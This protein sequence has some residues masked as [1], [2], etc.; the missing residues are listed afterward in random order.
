MEVHII[1]VCYSTLNYCKLPSLNF[2]VPGPVRS[3]LATPLLVNGVPALNVRWSPPVDKAQGG[4][5]YRLRVVPPHVTISRPVTTTVYIVRDLRANTIYT[6]YV[7]AGST[8]QYGP[9]V[10]TVATTVVSE[11]CTNDHDTALYYPEEYLVM[12]DV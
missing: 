3:L 12:S 8:A 11:C 4:L 1:L 5:T 10:S 7:S 2:Q 6:V 9:E